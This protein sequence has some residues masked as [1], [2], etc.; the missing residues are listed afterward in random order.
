MAD[1]TLKPNFSSDK[2]EFDE[3][4]EDIEINFKTQKDTFIGSFNSW[5]ILINLNSSNV[6]I[7]ESIKLNLG[8]NGQYKKTPTFTLMPV[9]DE[10]TEETTQ[11]KGYDKSVVFDQPVEWTFPLPITAGNLTKAICDKLGVVV[12]SINFINSDFVI[13]RQIADEKRTYRELIGMISAI[14][15]GNAFINADDELEIRSFINVN[16]EIEEYFSSEKFVEVGP[17]TGVNLAREP[18]KDYIILNDSTMA[19]KTGN[20]V[21]KIINNLVVDDNRELAITKIYNELK[22]LKFYCKKIETHEAYNI[23]PFSFVKCNGVSVLA[24]SICIKYPSLIDSYI[25]SNQLNKVESNLNIDRGIKKRLIN[26]EAKVNEVEGKITLLSEEI[27]DTSE[28]MASLELDMKSIQT[29]VEDI[30][31]LTTYASGTIGYETSDTDVVVEKAMAGEVIELSIRSGNPEFEKYSE[32][33][34]HSQYF[35][36][37]L[38]FDEN[39][40]FYGDSILYINRPKNIKN[41]TNFYWEGNYANLDKNGHFF[42]T[43]LSACRSLI[44]GIEPNKTYRVEK[45]AGSRFALGTYIKNDNSYQRNLMQGDIATNYI[46]DENEGKGVTSYEIIS[47]E[48]D[49]L[50]CIFYYDGNNDTLPYQAILDSIEI[51]DTSIHCY[52]YNLKID[53]PLRYL[54]SENVYDEFIYQSDID[55]NE[56]DEKKQYKA[57]VIRRVGVSEEGAWYR[58]PEEKIEFIDLDEDI[59][60]QEGTNYLSL[61]Y[62]QNGYATI[63]YVQKNSFTDKFAT[64]YEL[65]SSITQLSNQVDITIKEKV[66]K[67]EVFAEI[68]AEIRNH[69][70]F[71]ELFG[72]EVIIKGE[73]YS[74]DGHGN[75]ICTSGLIGGWD[76]SEEAL[77]SPEE[78]IFDDNN[79]PI[80]T[81]RYC[82]LVGKAYNPNYHFSN[83]YAQFFA[84][85]G[86]GKDGD[87]AFY[88]TTDGKI[89]ARTL[90][91]WDNDSKN[92]SYIKLYNPD[93]QVGTYIDS[94]RIQSYNLIAGDGGANLHANGYCLHGYGTA[95]HY[96][97][98]WEQDAVWLAVDDTWVTYINANSSSDERLKKDIKLIDDNLIKAIEEVEIK[99]FKYIDREN[100]TIIGVVAQELIEIFNKY[101]LNYK[102][103]GIVLKRKLKGNDNTEYY[104][105]DY[106]QLLLLKNKCLEEKIKQFENR[107][108]KIEK[109]LEGKL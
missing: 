12:K 25:S 106:E 41:N 49:T 100:Q 55:E 14:A 78:I 85:D 32:G 92:P 15:A 37:D 98:D 45:R 65:R 17:I 24:D 40:D 56:E 36:D 109:L 77:L 43:G 71:I 1:I 28:K 62:K 97:C 90:D 73:N 101:E 64:T 54:T 83:G 61:G 75:M 107:L 84:G 74:V 46:S 21:V 70:G 20:C 94:G 91:M 52:K 5:E 82:G 44:V 95:H 66:G 50:L 26:A 6:D 31:D 89:N 79:Q 103:Y 87:P 76:I 33:T 81:K 80:E 9:S 38:I 47:G 105:I 86:L 102:D 59:N 88:V 11:I 57:K 4:I 19:A 3:F 2:T 72:D 42:N 35:S 16:V 58:L 30:E 99:Q 96:Q 48:K 27:N 7:P 104:L 63:R 108:E 39:T 34:F 18:I 23:D 60:L 13:Y 69:R 29:K 53:E 93:R 8:I 10:E 68:N 22:G 67:N 51:I